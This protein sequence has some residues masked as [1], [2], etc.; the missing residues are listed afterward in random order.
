M[1]DVKG[2]ILTIDGLIRQGSHTEAN[3]ELNRLLLTKFRRTEAAPIA[4]LARRLSR[5]EIGVKL[6]NQYVRPSAKKMTQATDEEKAEYAACLIRIGV[7]SEA[8]ELLNQVSIKQVPRSLLFRAFGHMALWNYDKSSK[9]LTEFL[10]LPNLEPYDVLIAKVNL[11]VGFAFDG[12]HERGAPL[13]T[14]LI[15]ITKTTGNNLLLSN[16]L[17]LR[18]HLEILKRNWLTAERTLVEAAHVLKS[19]DTY[20]AFLVRKKIATL[21]ILKKPGDE[22]AIE[23]INSIKTEAISRRFWESARECDFYLALALKDKSLGCYLYFGTPYPYYRSKILRE[24]GFIKNDLKSDYSFKLGVNAPAVVIDRQS[25]ENSISKKYL[26]PGQVQQ[27]LFSVLT[28]DFYKP[29]RLHELFESVFHNE[30]YNPNSSLVKMHQA[31]KR[32]RSFFKAARLPLLLDEKNG[33]FKLNA[34]SGKGA[35]ILCASSKAF[36]VKVDLN[37]KTDFTKMQRAILKIKT[38]SG[39]S[40][41]YKRDIQ[42]WFRISARSA[43]YMIKTLLNLNLLTKHGSGPATY[44][45]IS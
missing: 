44:Y 40:P 5:S 1:V 16:A 37:S 10:S 27:R 43:S 41:I 39:E 35:Q 34:Q 22:K 36:V 2:A 20:D 4:A 9:A 31:C 30:Y 6:L 26:K 13:V 42:K 33:F 15:E 12:D 29:K 19:P 21:E 3:S 25:G 11:A 24:L 14:E 45:K 28:E 18:A 8:Q 23:Y 7:L 32:L 38:S 17:E